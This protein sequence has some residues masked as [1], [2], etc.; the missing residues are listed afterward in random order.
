MSAEHVDRLRA[1][2]GW[3]AYA[4]GIAAIAGELPFA[5]FAFGANL[6]GL[7][8]SAAIV[9]YLLALPIT[10]AL[11]RLV[12]ARAPIAGLAI[13][14]VGII[15]ILFF[16]VVQISWLLELTDLPA[17]YVLVGTA[18]LMIGAWLLFSSRY[19]TT[20]TGDSGRARLMWILAATYFGYPVWA[21]WLGR[22]LLADRLVPRHGTSRRPVLGGARLDA[23][24]DGDVGR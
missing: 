24:T 13:T 20:A 3:S 1:T 8:D 4:S 23:D 21:L 9:Q 7:N 16:A 5:T 2:A 22:L 12:R 11:Y 6:P 14:A 19:L 18:M 10:L 17:Y 15:G